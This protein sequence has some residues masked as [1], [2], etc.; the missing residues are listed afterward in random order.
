MF[1]CP[2]LAHITNNLY[3]SF[4]EIRM[5]TQSNNK[6]HIFVSHKHH[7]DDDK[8]LTELLDFMSGAVDAAGSEIWTDRLI[9]VGDDWDQEIHKALAA[10]DIAV[11][12]V[13]QQ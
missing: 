5:S 1:S 2:N 6:V 3:K 13:S 8:I 7:Q 9:I 4:E 11:V 12:L 10:A